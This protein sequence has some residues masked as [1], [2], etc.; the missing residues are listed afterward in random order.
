MASEKKDLLDGKAEAGLV[1]LKK[2]YYKFILN[3]FF[4]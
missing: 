1:P 2:F 3:Y 4:A